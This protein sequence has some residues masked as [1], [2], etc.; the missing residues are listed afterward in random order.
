MCLAYVT[1]FWIIFLIPG[2]YLNAALLSDGIVV[3]YMC[4]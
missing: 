3:R 2:V 1:L 4:V